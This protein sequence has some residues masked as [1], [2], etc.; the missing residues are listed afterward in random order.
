MPLSGSGGDS[1]CTIC[2]PIVSV[3]TSSGA[4]TAC[5]SHLLRYGLYSQWRCGGEQLGRHAAHSHRG[6]PQQRQYQYL[7]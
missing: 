6:H 4:A 2:A 1:S 3:S 5:R 7:R